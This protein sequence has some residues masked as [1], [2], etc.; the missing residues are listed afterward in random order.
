[1][2]T[3]GLGDFWGYVAT[4]IVISIVWFAWKVPPGSMRRIAE[5]APQILWL[6]LALT[7]AFGISGAA[8]YIGQFTH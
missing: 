6:A 8:I 4:A 2:A 3:K 1:M 5:S 7:I